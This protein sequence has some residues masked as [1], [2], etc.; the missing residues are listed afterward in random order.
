MEHSC[1]RCG[2]VNFY[3]K[4]YGNNTG[5]HC[6]DCDSWIAWLS[7]DE[8][9]TFYDTKGGNKMKHIRINVQDELKK[10]LPETLEK[11]LT[12][13]ETICPV[14]NGL[15]IIKRDYRF[16]VQEDEVSKSLNWYDNE[17]LTLCPNCYFGRIKV[18]EFCGKPLAKGSNHCNCNACKEKEEQERKEKYQELINKAKEIEVGKASEFVYDAESEQYFSDIDEFV[19]HYCDLYHEDYSGDESFDEYFEKYVPKILWTCE[20]VKIS[21]NADSIIDDACYDLHEDARDNIEDVK[22]LQEFLNKW[23]AKQSGTTTYYPEYDEYVKVQREWF[24]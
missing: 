22:E 16:G 10:L 15:G 13:N 9:Q 3:L 7:Q 1:R 14:C 24:D 19:G 5:L 20:E 21:M 23:C 17:Y 2:S 12:E 6:K 4:K 8:I 11:D 18:C